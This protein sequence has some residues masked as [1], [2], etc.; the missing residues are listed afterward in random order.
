[1]APAFG[2]VEAKAL[3]PYFA[4]CSNS[5]SNSPNHTE[6][7]FEPFFVRQLS[8]KWCEAIL[9]GESAIIN[10]YPWLR[11]ATLDA[12]V[13]ESWSRFVV[14]INTNQHWRRCS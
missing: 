13:R 11:K 10:V 12:Y 5:V 2:L 6:L 9:S 4:Q 14:L 8:D 7:E 1:M 3:Y